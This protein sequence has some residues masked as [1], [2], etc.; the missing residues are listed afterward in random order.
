MDQ[1]TGRATVD[2]TIAAELG[3]RVDEEFMVACVAGLGRREAADR[4]AEALRAVS[5]RVTCIH[6]ER[7]VVVVAQA[8][9]ADAAPRRRAC[10][11]ADR[12]NRL[13]ISRP[14]PAGAARPS[15]TRSD[16]LERTNEDRRMVDFR[17]DWLMSCLKRSSRG[18][19]I[20]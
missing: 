14:G 13:G 18:S 2:D 4:L 17:D 9:S 8:L 12:Q 15:G 10:D 5:P 11:Q 16:A 19:A 3:Y 7:R 6:H 1:L 20:A